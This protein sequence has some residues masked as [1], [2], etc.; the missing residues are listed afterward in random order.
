[1]YPLHSLRTCGGPNAFTFTIVFIKCGVSSSLVG[2]ERHILKISD[3]P[4]PNMSKIYVLVLRVGSS[5]S[6]FSM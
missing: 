4:S 3:I 2:Q 5:K 1:M 6:V